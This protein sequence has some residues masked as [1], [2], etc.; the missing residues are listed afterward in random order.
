MLR[1]SLTYTQTTEKVYR[2]GLPVKK[3]SA[4]L[5]LD[6]QIEAICPEGACACHESASNSEKAWVSAWELE[7]LVSPLILSEISR[8]MRY[9]KLQ[10]RHRLS[11]PQ[12]DDLMA[13]Y[14]GSTTLTLGDDAARVGRNLRRYF[15]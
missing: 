4:S 2:E 3:D 11:S 7:L 12:L 5:P 13:N 6:N 14:A 8:L 15:D 1:P 9:S 10:K